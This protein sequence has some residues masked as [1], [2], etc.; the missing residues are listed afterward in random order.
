VKI[1]LRKVLGVILIILGFIALITPFTPGSWLLLVGL[2]ILGLR[3]LLTRKL[4]SVSR[5]ARLFLNIKRV[6][7]VGSSPANPPDPPGMG[8]AK[9]EGNPP[10]AGSSH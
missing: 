7:R 9:S 5:K 10:H 2:E 6:F 8:R 1:V 4:S 3:L